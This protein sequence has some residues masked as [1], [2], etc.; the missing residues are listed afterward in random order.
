MILVSWQH[1]V[2]SEVPNHR[3]LSRKIRH[4]NDC[5][6]ICGPELVEARPAV[7]TSNLVI[8]LDVNLSVGNP[9]DASDVQCC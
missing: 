9:Q 1:Y 2:G 3:C 8:R 7:R 6:N 5:S 4:Y